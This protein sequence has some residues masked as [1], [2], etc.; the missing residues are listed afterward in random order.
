LRPHRAHAVPDLPFHAMLQEPL[1]FNTRIRDAATGSP[2]TQARWLPVAEAG[3]RRVRD[4]R[5]LLTGPLPPEVTLAQRGA[6]VAALPQ[7]WA[8]AILGAE[9]PAE[10]LASAAPGARGATAWRR[11]EAEPGAGADGAGARWA[12]HAL[13]GASGRLAAVAGPALCAAP[14]HAHPAL[15]VRWDPARPWHVRKGARAAAVPAGEQP[16]LVCAWADVEVDP[17]GWAIGPRPCTQLVVA[18]AGRRLQAWRLMQSGRANPLH[19]P[20]RP[21]I[22][23]EAGCSGLRA[24]EARWAE[25]LAGRGLV[26][27][28]RRRAAAARLACNPAFDAAWMHPRSARAP[29]RPRGAIPAAPAAPAAPPRPP[30]D[31]T[32]DVLGPSRPA[33]AAAPVGLRLAAVA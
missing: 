13:A 11:I 12:P 18:A 2:L 10:W 31:D 4:L 19:T 20:L 9:E 5:R 33:H 27:R 1:F 14:Q 28:L 16:F 30:P 21:P 25:D 8:E 3:V 23:E 24:L 22:W 7:V 29:P 15:V 26:P 17:G 32:A 6:L